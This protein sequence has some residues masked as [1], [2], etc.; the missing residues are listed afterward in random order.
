MVPPSLLISEISQEPVGSPEL[1]EPPRL[2]P[3]TPDRLPKDFPE[4]PPRPPKNFSRAFGEFRS[5]RVPGVPPGKSPYSFH[6]DARD[7]PQAPR[8]LHR[9]LPGDCS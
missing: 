3:E 8:V 9:V 4:I 7:L 1:P 2:F 6:C 5:A